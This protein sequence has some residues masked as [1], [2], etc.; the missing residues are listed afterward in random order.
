MVHYLPH[1]LL[2]STNLQKL[3]VRCLVSWVKPELLKHHKE[4]SD[5]DR[6]A[7]YLREPT[8]KM[9][10]WG[11]DPC[12]INQIIAADYRGN[13]IQC[14]QSALVQTSVTNT[15]NLIPGWLVVTLKRVKLRTETDKTFLT[16]PVITESGL[17][18]PG[19]RIVWQLEG[20]RSVGARW[21][22]WLAGLRS[23]TER[24]PAIKQIQQS[25]VSSSYGNRNNS[26]CFLS[27]MTIYQFTKT[28]E[29]HQLV[30]LV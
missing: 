21:A 25:D 7:L 27:I 3:Y 19:G 2:H 23:P 13:T 29:L 18:L 9:K 24:I 20:G 10:S 14:S 1:H 17:E 30:H 12:L 4:T 22:R 6:P 16:A 15:S 11:T 5:K 26:K 8:G 28:Q